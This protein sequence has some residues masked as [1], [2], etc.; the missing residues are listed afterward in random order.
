MASKR[1]L[2]DDRAPPSKKARIE[3]PDPALDSA[4]DDEEDDNSPVNTPFTPLTPRSPAPPRAKVHKCA[5]EGCGKAFNRPARLEEHIRSHT[6]EKPFK[7]P[8][9]DCDKVFLRQSHLTHHTKSAHSEQ[10]DHVC[11]WQDCGK[12]FLTATRLRRH[13]KAHEGREQFRCNGYPPCNKTFRKHAT[14][15]RHIDVDHFQLKAFTCSHS[16]PDTGLQCQEGF[17]T[18]VQLRAH[19]AR[20]HGETRYWCSLCP[21]QLDAGDD[22]Q[23][24]SNGLVGFTSYLD[25]QAHTKLVHPPTCQHCSVVC[26]STRELEKHIDIYHTG[27]PLD[28]RR[29]YLCTIPNCGKG[30]TK[31]GNLNIHIRTVH[32]QDKSF[33]CGTED[34]SSAP[35]LASWS[36]ANACGRGFGVKA[37]LESHIRS[38][39][40]G[41]GDEPLL[42]K[43]QLRQLKKAAKEAQPTT[44]ARL[45]GAGYAEESGRGVPC[46]VAGC[47]Y[48]F[49]R[50]IDMAAHARATH[51]DQA[52]LDDLL[53][54]DHD[55]G[56]ETPFWFGGLEEG[57]QI[58]NAEEEED[59]GVWHTYMDS[60]AEEMHG[61]AAAEPYH[62]APELAVP[63]LQIQEAELNNLLQLDAYQGEV[64]DYTEET[65][66]MIDP[67]LVFA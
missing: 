17:D 18:A 32:A 2:G 15:Q 4:T 42:N 7:C 65:Q 33:I 53:V 31:Q 66:P 1:Q 35:D 9:P 14:L 22:D 43:K 56:A 60:R 34:V 11:D 59:E 58:Y 30:F 26:S 10:R 49:K 41:K 12:S 52:G 50:H 5:I 8:E 46:V 20:L 55:T 57:V 47:E 63:S 38:Q 21:Q 51:G 25:L 44:F 3:S 19:E 54:D 16:D 61:L 64:G 45:T 40:L 39:H 36:G 24:P 29:T 28:A 13:E 23:S 48:L 62:D 37:T 27:V 67:A 6:G